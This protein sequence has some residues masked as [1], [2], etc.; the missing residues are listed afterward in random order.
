VSAP[1]RTDGA[2]LDGELRRVGRWLGP[3]VPYRYRE[4]FLGDMAEE[5]ADVA[6]RDGPEAARRW[7]RG[8]A[9]RSAPPLLLDLFTRELRM[10]RNRW[11][12]L[13]AA[14]PMALVQ[15]WDSRVLDAGP[16]VMALVGIAIAVPMLALVLTSHSGVYAAAEGVAIML[17]LAA[18]VA[19]PV[20]LPAL[21]VVA[22]VL[23]GGLFIGTRPESTTPPLRPQA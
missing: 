1:R 2:G 20:P 5:A 11:L 8:Q 3:L 14:L 23:A 21:G 13:A 18:K 16:L 19:T 7:L 12:G 9:L 6:R 15:A 4:A 17:L 10:T 22:L